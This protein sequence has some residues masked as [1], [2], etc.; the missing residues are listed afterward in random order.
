MIKCISNIRPLPTLPK[1][2][3]LPPIGS[4]IVLDGSK[5][6]KLEVY[7]IT[8]FEKE[9]LWEVELYIP[10][11]TNMNIRQWYKTVLGIN[12]F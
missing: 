9:D 7:S 11:N 8:Y 1:L 10:K 2:N 6:V 12:T 4:Y 3:Y 5:P